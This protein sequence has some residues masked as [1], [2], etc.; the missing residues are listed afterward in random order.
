MILNYHLKLLVLILAL[1]VSEH[2]SLPLRIKEKLINFIEYLAKLL[3]LYK[4]LTKYSK[5]D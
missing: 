2:Q 5:I 4:E 1:I 3:K